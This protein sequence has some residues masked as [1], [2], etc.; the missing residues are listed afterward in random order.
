MKRMRAG[1]RIVDKPAEP[2]RQRILRGAVVEVGGE[3]REKA[4]GGLA[5]GLQGEGDGGGDEGE[6]GGGEEGEAKC[7]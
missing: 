3:A 6:G 2:I 1:H 5:A 4:Q 7:R